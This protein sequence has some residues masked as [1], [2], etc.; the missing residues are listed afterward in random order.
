MHDTVPL[1]RSAKRALA[2]YILSH[3]IAIRSPTKTQSAAARA[4]YGP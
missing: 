4:K 2:F 1:I 3:H